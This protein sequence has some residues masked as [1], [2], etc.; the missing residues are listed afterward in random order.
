MS[1]G[2]SASLTHR[3]IMLSLSGLMVGMFI[4]AIDQTIVAT[5]IPAIVSD[6]GGIRYL[7][8]IVVG[9]L[10][11]STASTPLWGKIGDL[12]GRRR[13][14]QTAIVVFLIGSL[15]CGAAPTMLLLIVGRLVQGVGGGGLYA[16]CFG[17]VGDLVAPRH[18]GKYISYFAGMFAVAGV[19]GPLVGGVLTDH[20][21]W[22]WI[23][24]IN[25]PIGIASL[26]V[27][28]LTLHL[29]STR[30]DAKVDLTGAALLVAGVV[31][32]VLA[33]VWG[34]AEY[35]W[36]SAQIIGLALAS[37]V[38]LVAFIIWEVRAE[39]PILPMRLFRN[40][41]V[42]VLLGLSFLLG[43]IF[44]AAASFIPLFMEGV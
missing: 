22:R 3:Q 23:F 27:T 29:P 14:F 34:G 20:L 12:F 18:R 35:A 31:C 40:P 1:E 8:W 13:M 28:T 39:E 37:T 10:L 26:V 25:L 32:V 5:A 42:A 44:Y 17:I 43:P 9:Y 6:L 2:H 24:T 11:T 15:M 21:G 19:I 7:S 36:G 33:T 38:L 16:L 30:R 4:A 41:V